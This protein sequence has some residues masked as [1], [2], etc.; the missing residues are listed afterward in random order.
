[1]THLLRGA[2]ALLAAL[3]AGPAHSQFG[4]LAPR[5]P[6]DKEAIFRNMS[7]PPGTVIAISPDS[8]TVAHHAHTIYRVVTDDFGREVGTERRDFPPRPPRGYKFVGRLAENKS[9]GYCQDSY[10]P[11]DVMVGDVVHLGCSPTDEKNPVCH[12]ISI[13][14]RPGGK[15]PPVPDGAR[16]GARREWHE[17]CQAYQDFLEKGTPLPD[18]LEPPPGYPYVAPMPREK[19]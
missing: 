6:L 3:V 8:I 19:K 5:P 17:H 1:M 2:A 16:F 4:P 12:K 10:R 7:N 11:A 18:D 15:V 13:M 9:G 14:R